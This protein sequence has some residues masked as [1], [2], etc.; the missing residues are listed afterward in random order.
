[1]CSSG[2]PIHALGKLLSFSPILVP[3]IAFT[4]AKR[5]FIILIPCDEN[6]LASVVLL[7]RTT[8]TADKHLI[9]VL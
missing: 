5:T 1:M 2:I 3:N 8:I 9:H 6:F 7:R 4:T